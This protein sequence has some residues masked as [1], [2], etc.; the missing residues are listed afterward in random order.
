MQTLMNILKAIL[1][2][3]VEGVT[4]WLP[5]SST[6]HMII[7]NDLVTMDVSPE[8]FT[9]FLTVIQLGAVMAV[10]ILYWKRLWPLDGKGGESA[11]VLRKDI[12]RL[13]GRIIVACLPAAVIGILFD[14]V[15]DALFYNSTCVAIALIVFGV[16]FLVIEWPGR[17]RAPVITSTDG[18]DLKSALIIGVFQVIAAVFP[19]T[20][21]SGATIIGALLIGISRP[22][23]AEFTFFLAVPVMFGAS[24]LK[25]F[26]YL[27]H[28][29]S[30]TGV[31]ILYIVTGMA[32]SF[33]VSVI[34][35]RTLMNYIRSHSFRPF[36]W[37]R[38]ALGIA[39]LLMAH[40]G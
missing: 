27:L 9:V 16:A 7:L 12:L 36:G 23:A 28:G 29:M 11:P 32:V 6:G 38:I 33:A 5:V 35:I 34:V 17:E 26:K 14:D 24:L 39:V 18:I 22:A 20:S 21:R 40:K 13:W 30:F 2:G 10:V 4:E 25:L 8:F 19:G 1:F 15:F 31:E 37:Y 3:I